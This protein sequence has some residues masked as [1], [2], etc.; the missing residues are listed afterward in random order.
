MITNKEKLDR[1][2]ITG[3]NLKGD[4]G[5]GK[6]HYAIYEPS[7][8]YLFLE[9]LDE[10][11]NNRHPGLADYVSVTGVFWNLYEIQPGMF[12]HD[13]D[14]GVYFIHKRQFKRHLKKAICRSRTVR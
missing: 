4:F 1:A 14:T 9:W 3:N 2:I 6:E 12:R 5:M 11:I 8:N 13:R 10:Q 7:F